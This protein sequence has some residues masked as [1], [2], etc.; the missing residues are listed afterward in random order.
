MAG[1]EL[2]VGESGA[3]STSGSGGLGSVLAHQRSSSGIPSFQ[4][5]KKNANQEMDLSNLQV[6]TK[7]RAT[8]IVP[9][10]R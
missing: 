3:A 8:D 4:V 9:R 1:V 10:L 2:L 5:V 7:P 6:P